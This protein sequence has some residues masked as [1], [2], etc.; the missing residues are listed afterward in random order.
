MKRL[1]LVPLLFLIA[2][3]ATHRAGQSQTTALPG[4]GAISVAIVPNPIVA[5][6]VSGDTYDF[7]FDAVIRET[8]GRA[9][10]IS[11]VTAD[12]YAVGGIHIAGESYDAARIGSLGYSLNVPGNGELRYHFVPR[13]NVTDDRIFGGVYAQIR[14]DAY[15][16][17]NTP[18]SATVTVTV[19]R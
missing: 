1:T 4:H 9:V 8:A 19:T 2:G 17:T 15:D 11:R 7:P 5:Q 12:V 18:T 14:V 10:T 13:K 16:D 3:C 6:R